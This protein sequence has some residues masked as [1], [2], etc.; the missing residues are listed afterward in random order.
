[1]AR[2]W[3]HLP[4]YPRTLAQYRRIL[5]RIVCT[6]SV[7]GLLPPDAHIKPSNSS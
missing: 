2:E 1:M 4:D 6:D 3:G 5:D 7:G